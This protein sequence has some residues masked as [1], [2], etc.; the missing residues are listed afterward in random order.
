METKTKFLIAVGAA[1]ITQCQPCLKTVIMK[2]I[3]SGAD[4][5]EIAEAIGVAKV[6][7]R[8]AITQIDRFASALTEIEADECAASSCSCSQSTKETN[9]EG[10]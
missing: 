9:A 2:T 1:F 4:E 7:R 5:K 3:N 10:R 6:V 8:N